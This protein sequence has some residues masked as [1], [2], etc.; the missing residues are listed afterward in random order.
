MD[1]G[2]NKDA[3]SVI[4]EEKTPA[5]PG[6]K[7][8]ANGRKSSMKTPGKEEEGKTPVKGGRRESM[9]RQVS[10]K[11]DALT[12]AKA[13]DKPGEKGDGKEAAAPAL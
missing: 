2:L 11:E 6:N 3:V 7:K 4:E 10:I 8:K 5:S 12:P 1:I 9:K 13:G